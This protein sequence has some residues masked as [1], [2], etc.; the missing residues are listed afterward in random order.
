MIVDKKRC[1]DVDERFF[2]AYSSLSI[3]S[4]SRACFLSS[5]I[6][7]TGKAKSEIS[8]SGKAG[9]KTACQSGLASNI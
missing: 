5:G 8:G 4:S 6:I 7:S 9:N 1:D 2:R 3:L